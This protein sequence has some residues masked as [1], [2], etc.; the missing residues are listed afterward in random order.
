MNGGLAPRFTGG[1]SALRSAQP[2]SMKPRLARGIQGDPGF[3]AVGDV[4]AANG[5]QDRTGVFRHLL[6]QAKEKR[7]IVCFQLHLG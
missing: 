1:C 2:D 6:L 5:N 4:A 3:D 7:I